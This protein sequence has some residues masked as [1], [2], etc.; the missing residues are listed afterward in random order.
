MATKP[1]KKNQD[2]QEDKLPTSDQKVSK[3]ESQEDMFSL[4]SDIEMEDLVESIHQK[5]RTLKK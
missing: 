3:E 1:D 4:D 5:E 2:I